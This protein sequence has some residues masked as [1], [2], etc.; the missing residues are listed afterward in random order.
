MEIKVDA[1]KI[2]IATIAYGVIS[3]SMIMYFLGSGMSVIPLLI[4]IGLAMAPIPIYLYL[5]L[6]R[7]EEPEPYKLLIPCFVWGATG[8]IA[9]SLVFNNVAASVTNM[10]E[11][12]ATIFAAPLIE[13]FFKAL[14]LII[15]AVFF[16]KEYNGVRDA[17][18]YSSLIG[19]GFAMTE[20][21]IYYMAE[22]IG[23]GWEQTL[24]VFVGRGVASFNAHAVFTS[25]TGIGI[26]MAL[27][28][29][30]SVKVA[31]ILTGFVLAILIH[32]AWNA[33]ATFGKQY[34]LMMWSVIYIPAVLFIIYYRE[35]KQ[36]LAI[37]RKRLMY[38]QLVK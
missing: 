36:V 25:L 33:S 21:V 27:N 19:L 37:A 23:S 14:P 17:V 3:F 7:D 10:T 30:S 38:N 6:R 24:R 22:F 28:K 29:K 35:K 34:F 1:K 4:G 12:Q 13:E 32:M 8:A 18:V 26:A 11:N 20:N 2:T 16:A 31:L 15:L 5:V 9:L